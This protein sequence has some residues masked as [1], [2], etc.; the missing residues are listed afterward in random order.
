MLGRQRR[1]EA[2]ATSPEYFWR[3]KPSTFLRNFLAWRDWSFQR[4][5]HAPVQPHPCSDNV[6]IAAWLAGNT[7]PFAPP[8]APASRPHSLPA[9]AP[10]LA[11][12]PSRSSLFS[13][14]Q[15]PSEVFR[16]GD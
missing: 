3:I 9:P 4:R 10:P 14:I 6:S 12:A 1:P 8:L 15:P 16:L 13:P 2:F 11:S 5:C 7:T